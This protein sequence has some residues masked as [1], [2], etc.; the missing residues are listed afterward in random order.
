MSF[1]FHELMQRAHLISILY[2]NY[3][4]YTHCIEKTFFFHEPMLREQLIGN[5]VRSKNH[6]HC[7]EM[8]YPFH[9]LM[10]ILRGNIIYIFTYS[11]NLIISALHYELI[12]SLSFSGKVLKQI[13]HRIWL[14]STLVT[15]LF[16]IISLWLIY[17]KTLASKS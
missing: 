13:M 11:L 16:N 14:F 12:I 15:Y 9:E 6:T 8:A 3:K 10:L 7:I 1:F 2:Q 17:H 4:Q 5:F